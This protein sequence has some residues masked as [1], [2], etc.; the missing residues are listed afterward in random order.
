M[1]EVLSNTTL[2]PTHRTFGWGEWWLQKLAVDVLLALILSD[3]TPRWALMLSQ[4]QLGT[5]S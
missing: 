5:I 3:P 4:T 1:E 2:L